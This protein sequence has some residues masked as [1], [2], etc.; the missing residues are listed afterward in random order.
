LEEII[1]EDQMTTPD[2]AQDNPEENRVLPERNQLDSPVEKRQH[3]R[4]SAKLPI[5]LW[6]TAD[7]VLGGVV[8]E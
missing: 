2:T 5:D 6:Q 1:K 4:Y 3:P 7:E 8:T